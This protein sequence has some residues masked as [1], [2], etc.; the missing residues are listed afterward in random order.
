MVAT[1]NTLNKRTLYHQRPVG[2]SPEFIPLDDSLNNDIKL[3]HIN[4]CLV[5]SH[6]RIDEEGKMFM[7]TPA[8]IER[9]ICR[10]WDD[11][12]GPTSSEQMICNIEK[13]IDIFE[14]VYNA[15]GSIVSSLCDGNEHRYSTASTNQHGGKQ[16]KSE[17]ITET[18]WLNSYTLSTF[19]NKRIQRRQDI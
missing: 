1:T 6:L 2:N 12:E 3:S 9:G 18:I 14:V 11:A 5:G 7:K 8:L 4:N 19:E 17:D 10:I 15:K 16:V 13:A